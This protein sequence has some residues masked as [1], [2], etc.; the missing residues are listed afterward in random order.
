MAGG[1][2]VEYY[3]GYK[4][5]QNDLGCEDFRGRDKSWEYG[6]IALEFFRDNEIPFHEMENTNRLIGNT[7]ND[8][9]A[10]CFAK[11]GVVYLVYLPKGGSAELNLSRSLPVSIELFNPREGGKLVPAPGS[12]AQGAKLLLSAPTQDDWLF[13]V[14]NTE[15]APKK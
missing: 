14:K 9:S 15:P 4:L 12:A 7:K 10:Y 11:E 1:A 2:G 5:P 8:N 13:L 6:R 3:F